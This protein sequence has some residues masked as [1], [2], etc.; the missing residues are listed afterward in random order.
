MPAWHHITWGVCLVRLPPQVLQT[1]HGCHSI[2]V[3]AAPQSPAPRLTS[4]ISHMCGTALTSAPLKA[5]PSNRFVYV[6]CVAA[7]ATQAGGEHHPFTG[8]PWQL[9][10]DSETQRE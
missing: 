4:L 7:M 8:C 3:I 10:R 2:Q 5:D 1:S 6:P 9:L